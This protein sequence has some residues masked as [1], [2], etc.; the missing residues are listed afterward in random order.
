[1]QHQLQQV[2]FR[3]HQAAICFRTKAGVQLFLL[4][5]LHTVACQVTCGK[6]ATLSSSICYVLVLLIVPGSPCN[7]ALLS[8]LGYYWGC[9]F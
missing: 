9:V 1:M 8:V 4:R 5:R 3:S 2:S 6:S 7:E